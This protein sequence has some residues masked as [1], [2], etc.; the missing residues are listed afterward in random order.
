MKTEVKVPLHLICIMVGDNQTAA[1]SVWIK[2]KALYES[3]HIKHFRRVSLDYL[4]I[5]RETYYKQLRI[6]ERQKLVTADEQKREGKRKGRKGLRLTGQD[7]ILELIPTYPKYNLQ[8]LKIDATL[9]F[10][11]L[12]DL[13]ERIV[14]Q[15]SQ[16]AQVY[17]IS[18][19]I[20]HNEISQ[21]EADSKKMKLLVKQWGEERETEIV[22][23]DHQTGNS[24]IG[25]AK[26]IGKKS[27]STGYRRQ[28]KWY[29]EGKMT[30]INRKAV[31]GKIPQDVVKELRRLGQK[32]FTGNNGI[33][34]RQLTNQ[35]LF[36]ERLI[37]C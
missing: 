23:P 28:K 5:C 13:L 2:L 24:Q 34:Y 20:A 16:S 9:P 19:S 32:I 26:L 36:K 1:L 27:R 22:N 31:L 29:D 35:F 6:L 37:Q 4:G 10:K 15:R 30:P 21:Q 17:K 11:E 7:N 25:L 12:C 8:Y 3:G 33:S 14:P 18:D